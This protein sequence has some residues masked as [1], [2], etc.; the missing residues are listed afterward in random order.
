M[1]RAR[2]GNKGGK[3]QTKCVSMVG[4][5]TRFKDAKRGAG[6]KRNPHVELTLA[7]MYCRCPLWST[8]GGGS[9]SAS[10]DRTGE[11]DMDFVCENS[12]RAHLV[13]WNRITKVPRGF[14]FA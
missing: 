5:A 1:L 8:A 2:S 7:K 13:K 10:Y 12:Y 3:D 9:A 6:R 4:K 14:F 11:F